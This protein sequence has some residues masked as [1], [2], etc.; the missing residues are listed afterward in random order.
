[1]T[2]STVGANAAGPNGGLLF[3]SVAGDCL[4][5]D[6][7]LSGLTVGVTKQGLH[8]RDPLLHLGQARTRH[9]PHGVE[10]V[11]NAHF[12]LKMWGVGFFRLHEILPVAWYEAILRVSVQLCPD[13]VE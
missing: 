7:E 1:M 2:E 5:A 13:V 6:V 10:S 4:T 3:T 12:D 9:V 8:L 11:A